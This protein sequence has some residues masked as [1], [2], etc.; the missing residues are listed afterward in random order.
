MQHSNLIPL[1]TFLAL[2]PALYHACLVQVL[3]LSMPLLSHML[4]LASPASLPAET[5]PFNVICV[6]VRVHAYTC[7]WE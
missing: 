1:G 4:H 3:L 7:L 5:Y 2:S 6:E